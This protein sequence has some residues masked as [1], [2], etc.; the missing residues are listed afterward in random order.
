MILRDKNKYINSTMC[1][2]QNNNKHAYGNSSK[3]K[4]NEILAQ[5]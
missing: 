4:K 3:G 1:K 5:C 2:K